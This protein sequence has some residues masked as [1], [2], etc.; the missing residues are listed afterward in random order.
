VR[1][2]GL[3]AVSLVVVLATGCSSGEPVSAHPARRLLVVSMPG[4]SW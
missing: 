4:V 3:L 2:A 1:R